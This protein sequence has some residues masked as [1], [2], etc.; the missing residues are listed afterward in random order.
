MGAAVHS[1]AVVGV[2]REASQVV[3]SLAVIPLE[4]S[5]VGAEASAVEVAAVD[6]S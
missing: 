5:P 2:A 1:D 3:V 6:K 4:V